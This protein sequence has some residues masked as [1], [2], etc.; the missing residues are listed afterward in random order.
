MEPIRMIDDAFWIFVALIVLAI[1]AL[2]RPTRAQC[3]S[4]EFVEGVRRDGSSWC[5]R[6]PT[7]P[8]IDC[9]GAR[10]CYSNETPVYTT[11]IK[12]YCTGGSQP[13][14]V[15]HRTVGCQR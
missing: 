6:S 15:D 14:V 13:I 12:I 1:G 10:R 11:P 8:E 7:G 5:V 9:R 4:N 2:K 3:A